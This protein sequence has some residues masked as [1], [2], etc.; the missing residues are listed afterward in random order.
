M[1]PEHLSAG[2]GYSVSSLFSKSTGIMSVGLFFTR[3]VVV[4]SSTTQRLRRASLP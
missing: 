4:G 2:I 3:W 1:A